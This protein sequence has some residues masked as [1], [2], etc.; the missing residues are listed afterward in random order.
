MCEQRYKAAFD[1]A[2][3]IVEAE[4]SEIPIVAPVR[5]NEI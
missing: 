1:L 4:V 5:D 2:L 3:A